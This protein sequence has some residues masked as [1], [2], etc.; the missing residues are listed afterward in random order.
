MELPYIKV[1][2]AFADHPKIAA[3]HDD[4]SAFLLIA[5][6]GYC[7]RM[8]TDG[9]VPKAVAHR[10]TVSANANRCRKLVT[11]RLL[12]DLGSEYLCHDYL[13]HQQSSEE[14]EAARQ[15][16]RSNGRAGGLARA[17]RVAK[18]VASESPSKGSSQI[19]AE[20]EI[21][22]EQQT[23][24]VVATTAAGTSI[25]DRFVLRHGA[26]PR[27]VKR[28]LGEQIDQ[29]VLDGITEPQIC[30]ALDAWAAKPDAAPGLLPHLVKP[31]VVDLDPHRE[32]LREM[33]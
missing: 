14:R 11:H 20:V 22:V 23:S 15:R 30:R 16:N 9:L 26:L 33:S 6:W 31:N 1:H 29:L 18:Q 21:E 28:R 12:E 32:H 25:L 19:Q 24:S 3:L 27:Q 2:D 7:H 17:K 13:E 4:S 5:M 8:D 10:L